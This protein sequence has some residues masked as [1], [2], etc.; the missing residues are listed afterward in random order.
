MIYDNSTI[1]ITGAG[2]FLGH[3]TVKAFKEY[4][5]GGTNGA[6]KGIKILM[7]THNELD[8]L[9]EDDISCYM[10][11][12][13]PDIV[14]HL[15]AICGGI[16]ANRERPGEFLYNNL[17]MTT[18]LIEWCARLTRNQDGP[19]IHKF[20][21]VGTVCF[22]SDAFIKTGNSYTTIDNISLDHKVSS[23]NFADCSVVDIFERQYSG[24]LYHIRPYGAETLT[25][26][27]EHPFLVLRNQNEIWVEAQDIVDTDRL[28]I[29]IY[30][31]TKRSTVVRIPQFECKYPVANL[32]NTHPYHLPSELVVD[33]NIAR[34][35]GWFLAEGCTNKQGINLYFGDEPDQIRDIADITHQLGF[36]SQPKNI[37]NQKGSRLDVNSYQLRDFCRQ[38]FYTS[39]EIHRSHTKKIPDFVFSLPDQL[40]L[41]FL[42]SFIDGDGHIEYDSRNQ[43]L[44]SIQ[45]TTTSRCLAYQIRDIMLHYGI[46]GNIHHRS[47]P[48]IA[49]ICGRYVN[50]RE[51][52][53][54]KWTGQN[55]TKLS[56]LIYPELDDQT[57][58]KS[59]WD[60]V[61]CE[62]RAY[63]PIYPITT[64]QSTLSVYNFG[65][66]DETYT[67]NGVVV[68]NCSYPKH[69]PI[70]FREE[71][72]YNGYPEETNAPYG[73]AKRVQLEM[74][75]AYR[76]QYGFNGIYLIPVNMCGEWDNFDDSSSHVIPA[77][78]KKFHRA[79]MENASSVTLWG[80]GSAS[81]EFLYAGD[82]ADAILRATLLYDDSEPVNIGTGNEVTIKELAEKVRK[83]VGYEGVIL[84][85][86]SKPNG[87]PR[88]CLDT[89]RAR[90][91]FG[92]TAKTPLD[93]ML[94]RSYTWAQENGVL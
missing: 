87:Q 20:V 70:P 78:L 51:S 79:K 67:A 50:A 5:N 45:I 18:N 26:T 89:S 37:P 11:E 69:T 44:K 46:F 63:V 72:L 24:N 38:H 68:H 80:D 88:R 81:R 73:I 93:D 9:E 14:I 33:K 30:K 90:V 10:T 92:F 56:T 48:G 91:G 13:Q 83:V 1:L 34:L 17:I 12:H 31:P 54:V 27:S 39:Q 57:A 53:V 28:V 22:T 76:A 65:T 3:H 40:Q 75:K 74:L 60:V 35:F 94:D 41:V 82:C 66:V 64:S 2:G 77:M 29:P 7:P 8:L 55:L 43:K 58:R 47:A 59:R 23:R 52:W 71:N 42:R 84:W 62:N 86:I 25:V 36:S 85:D 21:G 19:T 32:K 61:V 4:K 16:G 49:K 6:R 15:A